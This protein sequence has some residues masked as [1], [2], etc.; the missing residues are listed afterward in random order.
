MMISRGRILAAALICGS[1]L[2]GGA[3]AAD[4][5]DYM[6]IV[7]DRSGPSAADVA[8]QNVL[9]LDAGMQVIYA[10]SLAQYKRHLL[11]RIPVILALF[12]GE[13]GKL[14]LYPPGK[15]PSEAPP[16]PD[17]YPIAKSV[18]HSTM[19]VYQLVAPYLLE[20]SGGSWR[21]PMLS[22][23]GQIQATL[24]TLGDLEVDDEV[25]ARFETILEKDIAFMD[26]C[27]E[28]GQFSLAS[29][30]A[31]A[32]E[33][34]PLIHEN[35]W[36]AASAQVKHW[37]AVLAEWKTMLGDQ[38]ESTYAASNAIYVTRRNNILFSI[39]AQ[40][41]GVE[42]INH[43]LLLIETTSFESPEADMLDVMT[44]IIADRA[45]GQIFFSAPQVMDAELLGD[46]AREAIQQDATAERPAILPTVAPYNTIQW[47]WQTD[48]SSGSGPGEPKQPGD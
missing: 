43:R 34:E 31:F 23:R 1:T 44:R 41:M 45:I 8:K 38:W 25:R 20:P 37:K 32:R 11:E 36:L 33:V 28:T 16:V 47:P 30:T 15:D 9:R 14:I 46:A 27:L 6:E 10:E 24:D 22:F 19:A 18:S 5:P 29:V 3:V 2:G 12:S 17:I 42:T 48:T 39:L 21:Q 40:F 4:L 35:V 7:V 26:E 13:G